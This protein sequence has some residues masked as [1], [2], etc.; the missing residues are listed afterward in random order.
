ME[1]C[2]SGGGLKMGQV[3][4]ERIKNIP[5][6]LEILKEVINSL[7]QAIGNLNDRLSPISLTMPVKE[8]GDGKM[9]VSP[10][11]E[12]S[13]IIS[14]HTYTIEELEM[15]VRGMIDALEI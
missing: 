10:M 1:F 12:I 14:A 4:V 6:K 2:I 3:E 11:S 15:V 13:S 8:I 9:G 5:E 7:A